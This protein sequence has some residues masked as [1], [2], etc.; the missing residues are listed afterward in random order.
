MTN[1]HHAPL[2]WQHLHRIGI[3]D[4]FQVVVTSIEYGR[5]KPHP[6]I[7]QVALDALG[8]A[9]NE[10]VYIGDSYKADYLGA[11]GVGMHAL[12]IDPDL[13]SVA[14]AH[15]KISSVFDA[16]QWLLEHSRS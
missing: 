15:H 4:A 9:P 13:E 2:I 11:M 12:L 3:A 10:A 1:T 16:E 7:F 14:A 8:T 6:G 5:P